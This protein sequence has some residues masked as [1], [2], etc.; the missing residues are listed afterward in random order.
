ML[1]L[2]TAAAIGAR[3]DL[4]KVAV[5]IVE[6]EPSAV[7]PVIDPARLA[8]GYLMALRRAGFDP[9]RL[10]VQAGRGGRPWRL[11]LASTLNRY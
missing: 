5:G 9:F 4:Q 11:L 3:D 1:G 10:P 7:I 6:I 2:Q 8:D